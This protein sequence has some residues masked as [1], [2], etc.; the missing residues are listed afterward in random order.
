MNIA[1]DATAFYFAKGRGI[2]KYTHSFL[3]KLMLS[4][5]D[6]HYHYINL[7][8]KEPFPDAASYPNLHEHHYNIGPG[9]LLL[10]DEAFNEL[11]GDIIRQCIRK[12]DIDLFILTHFFDFSY[13]AY[14]PEWYSETKTA[15]IV[16]DFI[17]YLM[18]DQYLPD[19]KKRHYYLQRMEALKNVDFYF[20]I[21]ES[22]CDDLLNILK[23]DPCR[24]TTIYAG[25]DACFRVLDIS[26]AEASAI[27][28][29]HGINR[30]FFYGVL[31]DDPRKNIER[32]IIAYSR[33]SKDI[34][35][36][37]LLVITCVMPP[38]LRKLLEG[39][40]LKY[41][42]KQH[43]IF[44]NEISQE[45][46]VAL[47]NLAELMIF[48][49]LYEGFGLPIVEAWAC[50]TPV[51]TSNVSSMAEVA[52][53]A[54]ILV[55]PYDINSIRDGLQ[56]V[57]DHGVLQLC[58][59]KSRERL[60]L[61]HWQRVAEIARETIH[62]KWFKSP[63]E[64]TVSIR[65]KIAYFSPLPPIQSGISD[66][67]VDILNEISQYF[68]IDVYIDK[69][70]TY[71]CKLAENI[72]V[73]CYTQFSPESYC[74]I[75]YQM[76]NSFLHTYMIPY[77]Q[78]YPG[79]VVMHKM[80]LHALAFAI[81][82]QK[83]KYGE[84]KKII[85]FDYPQEQASIYI[86]GVKDGST[87]VRDHD[88]PVNGFV[89]SNANGVIVHSKTARE[90]LLRR[91]IGLRVKTIPSYVTI[92]P[93]QDSAESKQRCSIQPSDMVI[94]SFGI[95][96]TRKRT[97]QIAKA[98]SI[99]VQKHPNIRLLLVGQNFDV[100]I[101]DLLNEFD[102]TGIGDRVTITGF[103]DDIDTFCNYIDASDICVNLRYPE[104]GES[105]GLLMRF[106][107]RGRAIITTDIGSFAEIPDDCCIKVPPPVQMDENTEV[108][109]LADAMLSLIEDDVMR[110]QLQ[111]NARKYAES[112]LDIRKIGKQYADF[113]LDSFRPHLNENL[114]YHVTDKMEKSSG[115]VLS[116]NDMA[117]TLAFGKNPFTE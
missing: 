66:Y 92:S 29:R 50:G 96:A 94:A 14:N 111:R 98:F 43:V 22:A 48:P 87:A 56:R 11:A 95:M 47:Y 7:L 60:P 58:I 68:D 4:D 93:L 75:V 30:Q 85:A 49:S 9:H 109:L 55:D 21:S 41:N 13:Y 31:G 44:T 112:Y 57:A 40:T 110:M 34:I 74:N 20:T 97:V 5:P 104:Y 54:C 76:G 77:I 52:G 26:L 83:G 19:N 16:Y 71:N 15:A 108:Q 117:R 32:T 106:L 62:D 1:F 79:V 23:I 25:V 12:Y 101:E 45:D 36:K 86:Q 63:I 6:T 61:Y 99:C 67:S 102:K 8:D 17:P 64:Q 78:R 84:Y 81:S 103:V 107:G 105:S 38:N 27:L 72:Q 33:L 51:L 65:E 53:D 3:S 35:K 39:I 37:Y 46:I 80:N 89:T 2:G 28:S 70:Y 88:M 115:S 10:A 91:N 114:L 113:V 100:P 59:N 116:F 24:S 42:I 18:Q 69:G 82:G 90:E 73:F